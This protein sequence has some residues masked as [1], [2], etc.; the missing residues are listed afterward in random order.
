MSSEIKR[1][2]GTANLISNH[3]TKLNFLQH[4]S[5]FSNA[6]KKSNEIEI[7]V[8]QNQNNNNTFRNIIWKMRETNYTPRIIEK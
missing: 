1:Q 6:G 7:I 4:P 2:I 5:S 8:K 3:K